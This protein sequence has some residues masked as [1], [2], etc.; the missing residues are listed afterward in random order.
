MIIHPTGTAD[1]LLQSFLTDIG[2][3]LRLAI[4]KFNF[5]EWGKGRV[6]YLKSGKLSL[7]IV[8]NWSIINQKL[9]QLFSFETYHMLVVESCIAGLYTISWSDKG[10]RDNQKS[11]V[12]IVRCLKWKVSKK[13]NHFG[14]MTMQIPKYCGGV[15][16]DPDW[17]IPK[18]YVP[19]WANEN[20]TTKNQVFKKLRPIF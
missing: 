11:L 1:T 13:Q 3:S 7:S 17:V 8:F 9:I 4:E 2:I 19:K 6:L 16:I 15:L 20:I 18:K 10:L 14:K 5:L 12:D